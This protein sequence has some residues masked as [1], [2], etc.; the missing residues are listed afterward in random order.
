MA[1]FYALRI[2]KG[3]MVIQEVPRRWRAAVKNILR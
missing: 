2:K 1:E 3:K